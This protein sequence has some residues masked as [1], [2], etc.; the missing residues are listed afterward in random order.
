ML[1]ERGVD[2]SAQNKDGQTPLHLVFQWECLFSIR[3][4]MSSH[5]EIAHI[6][7]KHGA[8]VSAQDKDG[9]TPLYLASKAAELARVI[10]EREVDVK[11]K[12]RN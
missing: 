8:D 1:V 7:I 10:V 6:L 11:L 3:P 9:Q 5:P 12:S 2:V 4:G